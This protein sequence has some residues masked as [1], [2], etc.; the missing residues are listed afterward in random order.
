VSGPELQARVQTSAQQEG[1]LKTS[2][3]KGRSCTQAGEDDFTVSGGTMFRACTPE[4]TQTWKSL[5][6]S[7]QTSKEESMSVKRSAPRRV[8]PDRK[9]IE[10]VAYRNKRACIKSFSKKENS[11]RH[12]TAG[13]GQ[14]M[15]GIEQ[16][17]QTERRHELAAT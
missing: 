9:V 10:Y 1:A 17:R 3:K 8:N 16:S 5:E 15:H 13:K 2:G 14:Q 6:Q 12:R 4:K 11:K 7:P